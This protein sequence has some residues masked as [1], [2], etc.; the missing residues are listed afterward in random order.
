M[1][2]AAAVIGL[3]FAVPL[4]FV[5]A[6]TSVNSLQDTSKG[7]LPATIDPVFGTATFIILLL[8][9]PISVGALLVGVKLFSR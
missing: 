1:Q 9:V 8:T 2:P 3:I 7:I 4:V 5:V 6:L